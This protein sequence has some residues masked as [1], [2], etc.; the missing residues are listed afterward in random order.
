MKFMIDAGHGGTDPGAVG[1]ALREKD[2]TLTLALR[3]GALLAE[4]GAHVC[5][6]RTTDVFVALTDRAVLANQA[7]ADYFI[8][9][10]INAG[11]G[12]GFESFTFPGDT[13]A[14]DEIIHR[15]ISAVFTAVE[16]KDRGRKQSNLAVLRKTNMPAVLLEYGFIDCLRDAALL[17]NAEFIEQL[18]QAS[19]A[20]IAE[21]FCLPLSAMPKE[22][23]EYM[24]KP[25]DANKVIAFLSAGYGA[26]PDPEAQAEFHRLANELRKASGQ[27]VE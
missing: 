20:G 18:A 21:A 12:T 2:L 25:E 3:I 14:K 5:F 9:V 26:T 4:R 22:R 6:T 10:H 11:G 23:V 27:P 13:N 1:N 15:H 24:L 8:S 17:K 16:M 7:G 19:A